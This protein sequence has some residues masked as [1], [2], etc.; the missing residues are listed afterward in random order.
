MTAHVPFACL[1]NNV[2]ASL[3]CIKEIISAF[4]VV[5]IVKIVIGII[6]QMKMNVKNAKIIFTKTNKE[7]VSHAIQDAK[8]VLKLMAHYIV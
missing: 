8:I 3:E 7:I 5:I 4:I 6:I 2:Y 1:A